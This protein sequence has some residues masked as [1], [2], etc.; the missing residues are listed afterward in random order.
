MDE[1][2]SIIEEKI[3]AVSKKTGIKLDMG[4]KLIKYSVNKINE[5]KKGDMRM[6]FEFM[7]ALSRHIFP[8]ID[9]TSD[10]M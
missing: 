5:M 9:S 6:V 8:K 3:E 2:K 1:I 7:R 4:E 10:E